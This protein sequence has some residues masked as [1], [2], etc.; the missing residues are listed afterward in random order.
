MPNLGQIIREIQREAAALSTDALR[1]EIEINLE[2]QDAAIAST[3]RIPP[4]G[5]T[6]EDLIIANSAVMVSV[7]DDRPVRP[8]T[9][10]PA[11]RHFDG[12]HQPQLARTTPRPGGLVIP[13]GPAG[14]TS[15]PLTHTTCL[16][17]SCV[18]PNSNRGMFGR[19][20]GTITVIEEPVMRSYRRKAKIVFYVTWVITAVLAATV[21]ASKWH[22]ILALLAGLA[23]GLIT[24]A[25]AGAIVAAWP[26][27]RAIWWWTPETAHHRRPGLRLDRARRAHHPPLPAGLR[28]PDR[29]RPRRPQA[30]PH[31]HPPGRLVPGHPAPHPDLLLRIHHH[32]PHR[33]PAADPVGTSHPRRGT[34][35]DL[36]APRPGPG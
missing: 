29:R 8:G 34:R 17:G 26:V 22:P 12:R 2:V 24:A 28:G 11:P 25:I 3:S 32:Q 9:G 7:A 14:A 35:V 15:A 33:Q 5:G 1:D 18:M 19:G 27:I 10:Y 21:A 4:G 6:V 31:P 30:G 23:V 13:P 16:R 20:S 36:A